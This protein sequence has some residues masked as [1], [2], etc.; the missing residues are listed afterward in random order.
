[1]QRSPAL[2][3]LMGALVVSCGVQAQQSQDFDHHEVHYNALNTSQLS[4]AMAQAYG[5]RRSSSRALLVITIL[6][7]ESDTL[8]TPVKGTVKANGINL[9]G[10]RRNID[11]S[12]VSDQQGA[13]YYLGQLPVHNMEIYDFTVQLEIE[14][15]NK[16]M[17]VEFRQQFYTE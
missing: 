11:M 16:P 17:V 8:R 3:L 2:V 13:V 5:I 6:K 7:K 14:G 9:T 4:P 15:E 1:M 12:E 10:Q